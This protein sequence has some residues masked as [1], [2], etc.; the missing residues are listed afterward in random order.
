MKKILAVLICVLTMFSLFAV[1]ATA[2]T[3]KI[4]DDYVK[5]N[6]VVFA[7]LNGIKPFTEKLR[8][9]TELEDT[10]Y[11]LAEYADAYN[12]K[13]VSFNG[14]MSSNATYGYDNYVIAQK[15]TI[16]ELYDAN[17]VD[18]EWINEFLAVKDVGKIL[19]DAGVPYGISIHLRD[20]YA[21]GFTRRNHVANQ[22]VVDDFLG[23][24]ADVSA[25]S[26]DTNNFA[27]VVRENGKEYIVF[28]LEAYPR[29]AVI[30]WF[31]TTIQKHLDKRAFVFT[32][33]FADAKGEM[34]TQYDPYLYNPNTAPSLGNFTLNTNMRTEGNPFDGESIWKHAIAKYDNI[35]MIM[36]ANA[37]P[38]SGIVT[39]TFKNN[40]GYP[41]VSVVTNLIQGYDAIGALPVLI[42]FSEEDKTLDLR[43]A[44]PYYEADSGYVEESHVEIKL[45]SLALLPEPDPTSL[46]P[47]VPYQYNGANKKYI[48]G[49]A[50]NL[51]K[52]SANMTRAEA[53]TI[54]ARLLVGSTTIPDG[55]TTR[56]SDVKESDWFYN[57][58]AYMDTNN[59]YM[60]NTTDKYRPN[61]PITRAEFVELAYLA[62]NLY[63]TEKIEFNDVDDTHPYYDAIIA[64]AASGLVNGYEDSTFRPDGKI[65]RAEVV[66]VINR[67]LSLVATKDT[68]Y[69]EKLENSFSDISGHWAEYQ[70][71]MSANDNVHGE[72]F[73]NI[74]T[75]I[76]KEN[77]SSIS[78]QND[79]L[80][81][82]INKKSGKVTEAVYIPTGENKLL[83]S[84]T[85]WFSYLT[86]RQG[87]TVSPNSVSLVDGRLKFTYRG[88]YEAYFI[89]NVYDNFFTFELDSDIPNDLGSIVFANINFD[90]VAS[91]EHDSFRASN[92]AMTTTTDIPHAP[93]GYDKH[94]V[95]AIV[96][97]NIPVTLMGAKVGIVFSTYETHRDILKEIMLEIDPEKG[98]VN[99][100]G[101]PWALDNPELNED[102]AITYGMYL[103]NMHETAKMAQEYDVEVLDLHQGG[104]FVQGD[105]NFTG[106]RTPEEQKAGK[107]IDA[108]TF[109]E[110]VTDVLREE[111]GIKLALHTYAAGIDD[112]ARTILTNPKWQKQLITTDHK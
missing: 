37:E 100:A 83:A 62:S 85:P 108:K 58:I 106:A 107:F 43:Y 88:G 66:T 9:I 74:D 28:Q 41:V 61:D 14:K 76:F 34:Y 33:S 101:G 12:I 73:Y 42:K 81:I 111:Y 8:R 63:A 30:E 51:F 2:D 86:T 57:A 93:G 52:P 36:S 4:E 5:E 32:T 55:Y 72:S 92:V 19:T 78:I 64:A 10:A 39:K 87:S 79:L 6:D 95:S 31:N 67:M 18:T 94:F 97:N 21:I 60:S 3:A 82:T 84:A 40:N 16:T 98:L 54:F 89:V 53:S 91:Y 15:K 44:V 69:K 35:V 102:Y 110:R 23:L 105:F 22:F 24:E 48:N 65:T 99:K 109:K 38:V 59:F 45:D 96:S 75:S 104:A 20:Y 11:W 49:Y 27:T 29:Q 112:S 47:K 56:F 13:Y 103:N 7:A 50:G 71:L 90:Y 70:I 77:A 68:V 17:S 26:Y 80:K 46:I 25:E 1:M